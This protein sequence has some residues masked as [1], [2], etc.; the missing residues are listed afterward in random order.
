MVG[1]SPSTT[2]SSTVRLSASM[3]CWCTMPMPAAMA[4]DGEWNVVSRPSSRMV[5][6][7]GLCMPYRVFISVD[8]PAPFSPTMAWM[9][10]L[11]TTMS[12]SEFATTPGKRL[13]MPLELDGGRVSIRRRCGLNGHVVAFPCSTLNGGSPGRRYRVFPGS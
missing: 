4:S 1:S 6:S 7:S 13:V 5:P 12:M 3:K 9:V 11:R 2:F 8:L 10:P